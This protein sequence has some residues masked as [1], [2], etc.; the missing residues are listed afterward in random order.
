MAVL[1][2]DFVAA[3]SD[4]TAH[5]AAQRRGLIHVYLDDPGDDVPF[6]NPER[7]SARTLSVRRPPICPRTSRDSRHI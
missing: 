2:G 1:A 7:G 4:Q 3:A 6:Q 5:S